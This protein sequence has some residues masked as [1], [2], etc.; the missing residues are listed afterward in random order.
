MSMSHFSESFHRVRPL[1][2]TFVS[3]AAA[4]C[5]GPETAGIAAF[6]AIERVAN[7]MRPLTIGSDVQRIGAAS[8]GADIRIDP[9]TYAVLETASLLHRESGGVFDPCQPTRPGRLADLELR[10]PDRVLVHAPVH[11]DLGG[12]AKGYAVDRA[13]DALKN[14]GC[15]RGLVN[16]GGDLRCFGSE[17]HIVALR[18]DDGASRSTLQLTLL[19]SALAVSAPRSAS[20]PSEHAGYYVGS[21]GTRVAGRWTAVIAPEAVLADALCKCAM[22]L[23]GT[24]AAALLARHGARL[25]IVGDTPAA[26]PA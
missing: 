20:S 17:P 25:V 8:A 6:T 19:D 12:I 23:D 7:Q 2:G 5:T 15:T 4:G 26:A 22:L 11:L 10:A 1:L 18:R 16:A 13:I 14:H 3:V 24:A 21:T 9:W